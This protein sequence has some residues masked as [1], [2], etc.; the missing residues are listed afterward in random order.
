M[1]FPY[2]YLEILHLHLMGPCASNYW[3]G[4]ESA[5]KG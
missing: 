2:G 4:K 1:E 5:L 3:G